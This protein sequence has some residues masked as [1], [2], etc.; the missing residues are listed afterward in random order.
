MLGMEANEDVF[1]DNQRS[2]AMNANSLPTPETSPHQG[3]GQVPRKISI[4]AMIR[5]TH[6]DYS[7]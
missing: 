7:H 2:T 6:L 1:Q 5:I 3:H 4:Q